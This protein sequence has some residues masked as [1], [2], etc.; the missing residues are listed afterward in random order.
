MMQYR[1]LGRTG[2]KVS[3]VCLGAMTFGN[4]SDEK[5]AC[6]IMDRFLEAGG[7]FID[8]ADVYSRGVSEEIVGR[9]LQYHRH[10]IVLA[11]KFRWAMGGGPNDLGASR[12][13]IM[14]AVEDSLRRLNV[15]A[16][17]LYQIHCW[18]PSTP[19]DETL[20]A[21]D[22]LVHQGKVRYLGASNYTAWQ[23]MKAL[24]LSERW[25]WARF[26]CLQPEYSLIAR[27]IEYEVL[28]LCLSE[29]I[30]TIPWSPLGGGFLTG[31][32]QRDVR[33][34]GARL[35]QKEVNP[36]FENTWSRRDTEKN[37]AIVEVV[38][39][40]AELHGVSPAQIALAWVL[41][42]PGVTAPIIGAR[43]RQQLEDNLAALQVRLTADDLA[44]LNAVSALD[45]IYP[46]RYIRDLSPR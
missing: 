43:T 14:R 20:R 1:Y 12:Y 31:K 27:G 8:T 33:P 7:N 10:E 15:E 46:Y 29:T 35:S 11:T 5:T 42:Q 26:E 41:A 45:D 18:D 36:R 17:D 28:P 13:Y 6:A 22:D 38:C 25:G 9:W 44:A 2:L 19:A 24:S 40:T 21:L 3:E 39:H 30:A 34:D 4:E 37:W 23:L 32:Y 16:I